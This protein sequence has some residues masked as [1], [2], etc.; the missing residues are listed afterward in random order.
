MKNSLIKKRSILIVEDNEINREIVC[1]LLKD[2]YNI[3]EAEDGLVGLEKLSEHYRDLSLVLLDVFMPRCNGFE[4]LERIQHDELLSSV[5][6]IVMTGSDKVEDEV[7]CLELG[8]ADFITKPFNPEIADRRIKSIIH[9]HESTSI[10]SDLEFDKLTGL[11]SKQAFIH[12]AKE[13]LDVHSESAT[14]IVSDIENFKIVNERYGT[15]VG[16]EVLQYFAHALEEAM[17]M[18]ICGRIQSDQFACLCFAQFSAIKEMDLMDGA[19]IANLS[20][21]YGIYENVDR[22]VEI[23]TLIDRAMMAVNKV[24][25]QYGS[26]YAFYD[27]DIR[28]KLIRQQRIVDCMEEALEQEQFLVYYQPKHDTKTGKITGAEALIRWIHPEY[29]FMSPGDFIPIFEKNGFISKVDFYVWK[30]TCQNIQRWKEMGLPIVPVSV[31]ASRKDFLNMDLPKALKEVS[32]E[33]DVE[34]RY[35]HTEVTESIYADNEDEILAAVK[36]LQAMGIQIEMDDFGSGY[37]NLNM[38][39]YIPV[40]IMKLDMKFMGNLESEKNRLVVECCIELAHKLKLKTVAEGVE[41]ESQLNVLKELDCDYIQGY[42]FSKP[43]PQ[44]DFE[45]YLKKYK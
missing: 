7:R 35:L 41:T 36:Q 20:V 12:Y 16:D 38:L 27:D 40:D 39:A 34:P 26:T 32:E 42:Y 2:E 19:P 13:L 31:N 15:K 33:Y 23:S 21:K 4:F 37:S 24:K 9:L 1:E 44:K 10:R 14:L 29:G 6:V 11:Y 5:P 8:A 43:L 22:Q 18:G 28:S 45:E 3:L 30:K 17:P 25:N